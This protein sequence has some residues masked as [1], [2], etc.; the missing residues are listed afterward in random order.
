MTNPWD[1]IF[2]G[3][4]ESAFQIADQNYKETGSL[5]DLR[6]RGLIK[7]Q[8]AEYA[9]A[10]DDFLQLKDQEKEEDVVGDDT[11]LYIG[12]CYYAIGNLSKAREFF[13]YPIK[14]HKEFKY[15]TD[16]SR[17]GAILYFFSIKTQDSKYQEIA[18]R[19]LNKR[20]TLITEFLTNK[21]TDTAFTDQ[22]IIPALG[23]RSQCRLEFYKAIKA[24]A[25]SDKEN[26]R[27][28]IKNSFNM[29][30][31]Y[32]EFEYYLSKVELEKLN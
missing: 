7:I 6:T 32:L 20:K 13:E 15:T 23:T 4:F 21:I 8:Q 24:L 11:Y 29:K 25:Q 22:F 9:G 14:H 1:K 18:F 27:L 30:G 28:H 2:E 10:L 19:D 26:Y 3:D 17:P 31:K 16:V 12:L 5:I